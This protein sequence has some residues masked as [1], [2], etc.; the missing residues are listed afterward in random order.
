M[1]DCAGGC[2]DTDDIHVRDDTNMHAPTPGV[3]LSEVPDQFPKGALTMTEEAKEEPLEDHRR[4]PDPSSL[5]M[6]TSTRAATSSSFDGTW[7]EK[8]DGQRKCH[9]IEG[10]KLTWADHSVTNVSYDGSG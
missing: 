10:N 5:P 6:Q 1:L 8:R 2:C 9:I 4:V 7:I 3:G